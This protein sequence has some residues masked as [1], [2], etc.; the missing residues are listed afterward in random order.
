MLKTVPEGFL[1][2][3][4][5]DLLV[6]ILRNHERALAFVDAEQGMFSHEYFPDYEIPVIEHIPWAQPPIRIPRAIEETVHKM[7]EEQRAA[8]KYEYLTASL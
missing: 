8:G 3:L 5:L 6:F 7:L 2:P 1:A 4:E